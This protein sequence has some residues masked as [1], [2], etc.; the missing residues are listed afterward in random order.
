MKTT[1]RLR[2]IQDHLF[3]DLRDGTWL[4]DSGA[5]HS[6]SPDQQPLTLGAATTPTRSTYLGTSLQGIQQMGHLPPFRG[7]IGLDLL[8]RHDILF[9]LPAGTATL[10]SEPMTG[11]AGEA[12]LPLDTSGIP[13]IW[14]TTQD[15]Y[16]PWWIDTGAQLCTSGP[17]PGRI[18]RNAWRTG[19]ISF[20]CMGGSRRAPTRSSCR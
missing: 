4:I 5:G 20:P 15:G 9:D 8:L 12:W 7:L 1:Y 3:F 14:L 2:A 11:L 19:R 6:M 17:A 16:A 10:S 13:T 18:P